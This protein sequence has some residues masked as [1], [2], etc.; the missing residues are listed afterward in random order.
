MS[1]SDKSD[2]KQESKQ[3]TEQEQNESLEISDNQVIDTTERFVCPECSKVFDKETS[4]RMH[5]LRSHHVSPHEEKKERKPPS[6]PARGKPRPIREEGEALVPDVQEQLLDFLSVFGLSRRNAKAVVEYLRSFGFDNLIKFNDALSDLGVSLSRRRLIIESW[7]NLRDLVV[8]RRLLR[9]LNI[10][11]YHRPYQPSYGY[12]EPYD[13]YGGYRRPQRGEQ[14]SVLFNVGRELGEVKA[15]MKNSPA[16]TAPTV[17]PMIQNLQQ[18]VETLRADLEREREKRKEERLG[19]I[20]KSIGDLRDEVK[21]GQSQTQDALVQAV[22]STEAVVKEGIDI[23]KTYV[24]ARFGMTEERPK[25]EKVKDEQGHPTIFDLVP[26][27]YK[28]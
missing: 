1:E 6:E 22:R 10:K 19:R 15:L 16:P 26:E 18:Q 28:E 4:L 27:E 21:K 2:Q 25:R 24:K 20:E 23:Y 3:K 12:E 5:R 11:P 13:P 7:S 17:N 14:E 8:P 9:H